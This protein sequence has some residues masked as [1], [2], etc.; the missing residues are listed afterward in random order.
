MSSDQNKIVPIDYTHREFSTIREDLMELAERLY[1]DSFRDWSE[2]SF[3]ALMIDAVAYVG[4]QLSFYLDYNVNETFMD[5]AY[6]YNNIVR[7]GRILGYKNEGVA[8]TYGTVSLY[9][10]VPASSTALGPDSNYIPLVARGT[11]FTSQTGLNFVLTENVDFSDSSN[12]TVV[13]AVDSSTGAPSYYA[14]KATGT[15]VSGYFS[16]E[17]VS[18]GSYE[19]FLNVTLSANNI[20]EII[21]VFDSQGNEYFEVDYLAQ[22]MVLK[23]IANTNYKSD[24]VPS[25]IKPY[26]VS[27]KFVVERDATRTYLQ[28][29]SGKEGESD[30]VADPQSVAIDT[31]GKSYITDTTFDPT[32]LSKSE[33]LG[34]VPSNTTLTIT[35]RLTNGA[36]S[37]VATAGLNTVSEASMNFSD[38]ASLVESTMQDVV[39]SL[40]VTNEEPIIGDITVPGSDELK[41]MI[42]D[43]F[44]TQNRAVT[45]ADYESITYR[46]PKKFGSLKRCSMQKDPN[47]QKRNLN[48]YVVSEDNSGKLTA[49]NSTIKDNLKTWLNQY[50][51]LNDTVDILDAYILNFGIDFIIKAATNADK[52]TLL[53]DAIA[54][55]A[56]LYETA[57]YIGEP[58]YISDIYSTLKNVTGVLDVTKVT[59]SSKTGANYSSANIVINDNLSPD[60]SYV[61]VPANA[62]V[63]IRYPTTDIRGK[64]I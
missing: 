35:Y 16:E 23:E 57:L 17:T 22:D 53:D 2:A 51:M 39:N 60:G 62:L 58:F 36:N 12:L 19:R 5:T 27:R 28:F 13:A 46:M 29:G 18:I 21:S 52:Y 8:S 34:V 1:P 61:I 55:L 42:F 20:A 49:T 9:V 6:Q 30:V 47:S 41:R 43:T 25:V 14:V 11:R 54:A 63:E 37:N 10:L 44:P 50:R 45:Q 38:A 40:E 3:G 7:H 31:Y 24:N 48:L 26:L 64:V 4:D 59:V 15:V 32:R 33:S 56:T